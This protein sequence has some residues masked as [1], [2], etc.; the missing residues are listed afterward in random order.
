MIAANLPSEHSLLLL[1]PEQALSNC[2]LSFAN[3]SKKSTDDKIY[4]YSRILAKTFI[5]T[6]SFIGNTSFLALNFT[7]HLNEVFEDACALSNLTVMTLLSL[8]AG[9]SIINEILSYQTAEETSLIKREIKGWKKA[10]L[11]TTLLGLSLIS[12]LPYIY[13][14][15]K[16]NKGP[17]ATLFGITVGIGGCLIPLR[18]MQLDIEKHMHKKSAEKLNKS[19]FEVQ[20]N[21]VRSLLAKRDEFIKSSPEIKERFLTSLHHIRREKN[22]DDKLRKYLIHMSSQVRIN[23]IEPE[24]TS[25][26]VKSAQITGIFLTCIYQMV[27]GMY[28]WEQTK[29]QVSDK[30]YVAGVLSFLVVASTFRIM[31]KSI[32]ES[33]EDFFCAAF[34]RRCNEESKSLTEQFYDKNSIAALNILFTT[35]NGLA[36]LVTYVMFDDLFK[37]KKAQIFT[38]SVMCLSTFLLYQ[39]ATSDTLKNTLEELKAFIGS[40][41][42]KKSIQLVH[43]FQNLA[44]FIDSISPENFEEFMSIANPPSLSTIEMT[45]IT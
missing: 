30:D 2:L 10:A 40:E 14:A 17:Y 22:S 43:E 34:D 32:T 4:Q 8:W 31:L 42:E 1:T 19:S 5:T 37:D 16:Y 38:E 27:V 23:S 12:Q 29:S 41:F 13:S 25:L 7:L 26:T 28:T 9:N 15:T 6:G 11:Y 20:K 3:E 21:Y 24:T 33:T 44:H 18:S 35:I 36:L 39:K 45:S